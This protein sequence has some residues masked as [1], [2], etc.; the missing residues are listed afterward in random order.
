MGSTSGF[1]V[2]KTVKDWF[3]RHHNVHIFPHK[4][5]V[6]TVKHTAPGMKGAVGET[7]LTTKDYSV[8]LHYARDQHV[9]HCCAMRGAA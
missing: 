2:S 7:V 6:V 5:F 9:A 1:T 4:G 3:N 8:V